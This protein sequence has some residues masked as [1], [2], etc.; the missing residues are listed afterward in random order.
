MLSDAKKV[1][2]IINRVSENI[3]K[4]RLEMT[5]IKS[6]RD[7]YISANVDPSGTQ[8]AGNVTALNTAINSLDTE[9]NK[10]IF[11]GLINASVPS[12]R[13]KAL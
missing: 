11:T 6:I 9:L 8:L 4:M 1:Q 5:D 10:A 2:T 12:H 13:G 3:Q 7:L